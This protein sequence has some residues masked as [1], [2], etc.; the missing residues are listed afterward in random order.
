MKTANP[1]AALDDAS[2]PPTAD[3][4]LWGMKQAAAPTLVQN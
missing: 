2:G 3:G 4:A 1:H